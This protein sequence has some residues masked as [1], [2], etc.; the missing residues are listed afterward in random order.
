M[1]EHGQAFAA[2]PS[3]RNNSFPGTAIRPQPDTVD[4]R[5]DD[6]LN[7]AMFGADRGQVG[8]V[9]RHTLRRNG[10]RFASLSAR[11][12]EGKSGCRS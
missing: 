10:E 9:M 8:L 6:R 11:W 3:R 1:A 2:I 5:T 4:G 7:N 12:V